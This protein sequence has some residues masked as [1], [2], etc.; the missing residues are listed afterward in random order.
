MLADKADEATQG[1][2]PYTYDARSFNNPALPPP[3]LAD[4]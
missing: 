3:T 2:F 1:G 4:I